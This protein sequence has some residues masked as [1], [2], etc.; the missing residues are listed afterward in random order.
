MARWVLLPKCLSKREALRSGREMDI[1][2]FNVFLKLI[3]M[4]GE[5][6]TGCFYT[7]PPTKEVGIKNETYSQCVKV[8]EKDKDTESIFCNIQHLPSTFY[9]PCIKHFV[10]PVHFHLYRNLKN[11]K[12]R[13]ILLTFLFSFHIKAHVLTSFAIID[14]F[15]ARLHKTNN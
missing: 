2:M 4:E 8:S 13:H 6:D 10:L 1:Y 9:S 3:W 15:F 7:P 5:T 12:K 11:A 14:F